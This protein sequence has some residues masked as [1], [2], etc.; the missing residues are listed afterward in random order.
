MLLYDSEMYPI[1]YCMIFTF[2]LKLNIEK[3]IMSRSFSH[4]LDQVNEVSYWNDEMIEEIDQITAKQLKDFAFSGFNKT[5]KF[6]IS[7]MFS[8]KFK[9]ISD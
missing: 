4:T 9:F 7:E 1:S 8:T 2:Q 3:I 6:S 5:S